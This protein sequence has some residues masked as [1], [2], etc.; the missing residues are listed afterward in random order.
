MEGSAEQGIPLSFLAP[1][2]MA[3]RDPAQRFVLDLCGLEG[4]HDAKPV[5]L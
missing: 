4:G 2:P 1:A 3:G 5:G